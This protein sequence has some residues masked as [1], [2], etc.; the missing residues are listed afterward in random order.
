MKNAA[1]FFSFARERHSIYLKRAAGEPPPWT[2]DNVL[3]SY[4]FTNVSRELDKTTTW[5]R[6]RVRDPLRN[7]PRVLFATVAF[8]WF[9]RIN[10]G[11][12]LA[13]RRQGWDANKRAEENLFEAWD[14]AEARRRL[15]IVKPVVTGA[16]IIKTPDGM[17]KL[18]GVLWCI[19]NFR[20][21]P[22]RQIIFTSLQATWLA[23]RTFPYLGDFMA[24]E[25]VE[26]LKHTYLLEHAPDQ[27][28]WTNPGPGCAR[29]LSY[30]VGQ[31][32]SHFDRGKERDRNTMIQLM[33]EMLSLSRDPANWPAEWFHWDLHTVEF[34]ACEFAKWWSATYENK[35]Q[36]R[37]Y[38]CLS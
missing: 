17:N 23:L 16:Y 1:A 32:S 25:V 33:R 24:A 13:G 34:V 36:K 9:N 2:S 4:R 7:D 3:Q 29:G 37:R 21:H 22:A 14:T 19:D 11:E 30:L 31:P 26:D 8:R 18:E 28:T 38:S 27:D 5:F 20:K 6:V 10:T 12:I 35:P 15:S